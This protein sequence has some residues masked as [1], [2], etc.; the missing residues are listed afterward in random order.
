MEAN[1]FC[2][3][4]HFT[5]FREKRHFLPRFTP[6]QLDSLVQEGWNVKRDDNENCVM[7][8]YLCSQSSAKKS[9]L[10]LVGTLSNVWGKQL[11]VEQWPLVLPKQPFFF[12][13]ETLGEEWKGKC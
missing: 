10:L 4:Q 13:S 8:L 12:L 9:M 2:F 1:L 7:C 6:R 11:T 3:S 5:F